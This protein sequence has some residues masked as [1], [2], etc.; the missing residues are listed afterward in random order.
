LFYEDAPDATVSVLSEQRSGM[1]NNVALLIN[2]KPDASSYGDRGTQILLAQ[3][4]L[5]ARPASRDVFC[6][7]L[8]SGMTAGSALK[9]PIQHLTVAEN[10]G[11]VLRAAKLFAP[12]NN[13]VLTNDRVRIYHEDAR[14]VLKLDAKTYDVIIS[15]PS[16]PW[17]VGIGSVYSHEFYE[18]AAS[19]LKPGGIFTQWFHIY[20]MDD[21]TL[22]VVLRTFASAFPN[23]E[24]WDLGEDVIL[25]GSKQP[26]PSGP[27]VFAQAYQFDEP[28]RELLSIGLLKP[29]SILAR[30]LASQATA[31]AVAGPGAVQ[32]DDH[33]LLE[34]EAPR[35]F[36]MY[37]TRPGVRQ[38]PD[39][40][41]RTWQAGLAPAA[42]KQVLAGLGL[43]DLMPIFGPDM[44]SGNSQ[45]QSLLDNRF[46]GQSGSLT[47]GNRIMPCIFPD[48]N[49]KTMIYAPPSAANNPSVRQLYY[50]DVILQT[51]TNRELE[52]IQT[53]KGLL[54]S[55]DEYDPQNSDWSAAYY[56]D[57]AVKACLRRNEPTLVKSILLRGL[58]LEPDSD[59]LAYLSRIMLREGIVTAA[60]LPP[61]KTK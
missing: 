3:L 52:A 56:A 50:C 58:Q 12:W 16:N 49:A 57:L 35:A 15:E 34:Y 20:S 51:E 1:S 33:P 24:I 60:E 6:F 5:M 36:Y 45:L 59:Q 4:P 39:Y 18:L 22:N 17:M 23:M 38:L 46:H 25:L 29:E 10:C 26:W 9:Y 41:E 31:F 30:Q 14:T 44:V 2:G 28:R 21:A 55:V 54:D 8:G 47:F 61:S 7:G 19:R 40:D 48:T 13:G 27:E 43:A 53:V 32:S 11:P 37:Q 42:K